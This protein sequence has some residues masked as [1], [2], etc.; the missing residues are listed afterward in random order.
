MSVVPRTKCWIG[1][2]LTTAISVASCAATPVTSYDTESKEQFRKI[3]TQVLQKFIASKPG[4]NICLPPMFGY[5]DNVSE[6]VDVN[7]DVEMQVPGINSGTSRS[8]Q[9]KALETAGLVSS[10]EATRTFNNKPQRILT[11]RRT[12]KGLASSQ[13]PSICYARGEL[14][15]VVKWKGPAVLGAYQA[16][17]VYYTV[18]TTDI[19]DWAKSAEIQSAFPATVPIVKGQSAKVRQVI[20]DL[21]SEGWDIAEYSKYVQLQ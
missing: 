8:A 2:A 19:S 4:P 14:D 9:F 10:T 12:A 18:K 3:F 13:G 21:S 1:C 5:G 15:Q 11:Y 16:A 6:T 7:P 20:I 17:F